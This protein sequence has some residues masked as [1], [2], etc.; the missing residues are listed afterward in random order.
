MMYFL[1]WLVSCLMIGCIAWQ[2]GYE[3]GNKEG[4]KEGYNKGFAEA[5]YAHSRIEAARKQQSGLKNLVE[6]TKKNDYW[7]G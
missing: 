1:G 2:K 4:A 7:I 6:K 5:V 3:K